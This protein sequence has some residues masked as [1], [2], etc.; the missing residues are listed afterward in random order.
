MFL[1]IV[2]QQSKP[3]PKDETHGWPMTWFSLVKCCLCTY[4]SWL[5]DIVPGCD[6]LSRFVLVP[7]Q[8]LSWTTNDCRGLS[9]TVKDCQ[10][11]WRT[12]KDC[13]GLSRT[14]SVTSTKY[15]RKRAGSR[16][17]TT[18]HTGS[19]TTWQM[20]GVVS[21]WRMIWMTLSMTITESELH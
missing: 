19:H 18:S 11:L 4:Y 9:R 15:R 8:E 14:V 2:I 5:W 7:R 10:W 21:K 20:N 13:Q 16:C 17:D 1:T 12:V 6:I 3:K